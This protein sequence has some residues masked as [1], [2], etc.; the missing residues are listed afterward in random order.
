MREIFLALFSPGW[1][2][3]SVI[4]CLL[5]GVGIILMPLLIGIPIA[6]VG[7]AMLAVSA[8]VSLARMFPG[9]NALVKEFE[10]MFRRMVTFL[11]SL[12]WFAKSA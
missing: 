11:K 6:G 5:M 10:K 2:R 9:G 1:N 12:L 8:M 3:L 7:F 4:G